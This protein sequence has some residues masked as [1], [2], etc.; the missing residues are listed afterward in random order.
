VWLV[1]E[2]PYGNYC[3]DYAANTVYIR[4][5]R[6]WERDLR[7]ERLPTDPPGLSNSV[8]QV[9]GRPSDWGPITA[10]KRG[11]LVICER[12]GETECKVRQI[13]QHLNVLEEE[14]FQFGWPESARVVDQRD[15]AHRKGRSYVRISGQIDGKPVLGTAR[16]PLV[17]AAYRLH[18]PWLDLRIGRQWRV[19]DTK[20]GAIL[21][22]DGR[23]VGQ[24]ASGS[25]FRGLAR[26][27]MGLHAIDTIRRD[28]AGQGMRSETR[29]D[30]GHAQVRVHT[31][32]ATLVYTIAM[33]LDRIERI[34]FYP[35]KAGDAGPPWGQIEFTYLEDIDQAEAD[36]REPQVHVPG[37]VRQNPEG[38]LWLTQCLEP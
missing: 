18:R 22:R 21:S 19:A 16:M 3:F 37:N 34:A 10:G 30:E 29:Y 20:D 27:W 28:A 38:M 6:T 7:I 15:A 5:C 31:E 32:A 8:P 33:E 11:L 25:F 1:L 14:Y 2:N 23:V 9:E 13:D 17:Y 26:P 24:Y 4:N 36:L 12:T 35:A